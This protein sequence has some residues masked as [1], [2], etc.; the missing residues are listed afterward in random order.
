MTNPSKIKGRVLLINRA[1]QEEGG[2]KR[3]KGSSNET[4]V[5]LEAVT[6]TGICYLRSGPLRGK[7]AL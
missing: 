2:A 4:S 5:L 6:A 1:L 3:I 7:A